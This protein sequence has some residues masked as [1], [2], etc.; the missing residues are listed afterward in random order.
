MYDFIAINWNVV[1]GIGIFWVV[2][3]IGIG[4]MIA[5]R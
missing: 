4:A 3:V 1:A 2:A 5:H